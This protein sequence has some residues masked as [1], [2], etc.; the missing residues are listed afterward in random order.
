MGNNLE[1]L[2]ASKGKFGKK[3]TKLINVHVSPE[4]HGAFKRACSTA[5][6]SMSE[7]L[8][9][10]MQDFIDQVLAATHQKGPGPK[11]TQEHRGEEA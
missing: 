1:R 6:V 9:A 7:C 3:T 5:G 2:L 4:L 11:G 10:F 8:D